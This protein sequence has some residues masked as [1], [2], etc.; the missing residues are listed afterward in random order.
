MRELIR[1]L[2]GTMTISGFETYSGDRLKS[3]VGSVFDECV[4]Y[5]NGNYIFYRRC[6]KENAPLLM[7]DAHYDEVGMI[8]RGITDEGFLRVISVGGLDTRI[9]LAGEVIIYADRELY[10]VVSVKAKHLQSPDESGKLPDVTELLID[11][12]FSKEKLTEYGVRLGTPVGYKPV[13]VDLLND[14]IAGKGFDDKCC[15]A[16]AVKAVEK[17]GECGCDIALL[18]SCKEETSLLGGMTGAFAAEPDACIVLDVNLAHVPDTKKHETVELDGG[19]S[20]SLSAVT[21]R[22]LTKAIIDY[23]KEKQL[24]YQTVVEATS[25]GTNANVIPFVNEGIPTAVVS[26]PLRNMHTYSEVISLADCEDTAAL[27][28]GF[29]KEGFEKWMNS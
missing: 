16:A 9:L 24:K 13:P 2:S 29:I 20:V 23:A 28:A 12:G 19:P 4:S 21:D 27:I 1:A 8:V 14:R 17:A 22:S 26:I 11:T 5:P 18:C 3:L 7:L 15:L 10:G 25:T 6:G